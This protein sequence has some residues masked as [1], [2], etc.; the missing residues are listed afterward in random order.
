MADTPIDVATAMTIPY[1]DEGIGITEAAADAGLPVVIAFTVETDG[2]LPSGEQLGAA[3]ERTDDATGGYPTHYMINCAHPS[4]FDRTVAAG[5]DWTRRI[6]AVRANASTLSHAELDEATELD[7]GDPADL[8]QRYVA[9]RDALPAMHVVGGC[10]GTDLRH[11]AAI[12][13][14]FT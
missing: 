10:C 5:G 4:H 7:D 12:A 14:A 2:T 1:I 9:L 13:A 3:I 6:A 8:A 11:V